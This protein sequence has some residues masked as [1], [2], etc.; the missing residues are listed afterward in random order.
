MILLLILLGLAAL[1]GLPLFL[2]LSGLALAG[3][4][5]EGLSAS[6]YFGEM[7]R[8]A[9]NPTLAAVPLFC[10]SGYLLA[11]SGAPGRLVRLAEAMLGWLPGGLA[12][13]AVGIMALLT[14]FTGAS[15]V[16][17][18]ALGGLMLPSLLKSNF[19]E[20]FSLGLLTA[21][22][23][24]GLLFAPSLPLILYG[25]V[26]EVPIDRLFLAGVVPG[27]LMVAGTAVYSGLKAPH[28]TTKRREERVGIWSALKG[29]IWEAILPIIVLGGIYGGLL[30]VGEAAVVTTA[31][32]IVVEVL[33]YRDIRLLDLPRIV[34]D[35]AVLVGGIMVILGA[36]LALTNYLIY[37]D[38]PTTLLEA[39]SSRVDSRVMFLVALN[40]FLLITGC[41]MDV[42]SAL[43]VVV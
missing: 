22:G 16:T 2:T 34:S 7:M 35:S 42:F 24:I 27:L 10:L 26:A 17:I 19:S 18:V 4:G 40:L 38:I 13:V 8:L 31:Y 14:A 28:A 9:G 25:I 36:A 12:I 20:R 43:V 37:A 6:L 23:S 33:I 39:I 41:L 3:L 5:S 11:S 21:S 1:A 32:L 30:T 15:G 29:A